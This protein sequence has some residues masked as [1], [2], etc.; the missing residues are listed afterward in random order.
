MRFQKSFHLI[1]EALH[2]FAFS[3]NETLLSKLQFFNQWQEIMRLSHHFSVY[4]YTAEFFTSLSCLSSKYKADSNL[5]SI[6]F[7]VPERKWIDVYTQKWH[8]V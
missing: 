5:K 3:M 7:A 2:L 8:N 1:K 6:F 4:C